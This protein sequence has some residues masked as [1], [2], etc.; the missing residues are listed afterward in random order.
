MAWQLFEQRSES[1]PHGHRSLVTVVGLPII[2][3]PDV[4]QV[5]V[6]VNVFPSQKLN[7]ADPKTR[8]GQNREDWTLGSGAACRIC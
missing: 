5:V 1:S 6:E 7:L 3:G 8:V 4:Q 2:F